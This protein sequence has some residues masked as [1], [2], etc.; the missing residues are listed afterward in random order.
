MVGFEPTEAFTSLA[1]KASAID[2]SATFPGTRSRSRTDTVLILSQL[3]LPLDY[4]GFVPGLHQGYTSPGYRTL[5]KP[6]IW[7]KGFI[8]PL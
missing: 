7:R 5:P 3:S 8:R 1:F 6:L 2:H 4:T